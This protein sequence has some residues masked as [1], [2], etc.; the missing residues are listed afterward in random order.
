MKTS[1]FT[2]RQI[3]SI[4]K[5]AEFGIPLA[6]LIVGGVNIYLTHWSK[7]KTTLLQS[8]CSITTISDRTKQKGV[9]YL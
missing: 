5:Q 6:T 9:N 4:L 2:N 7:C 8:G 1:K 3:M